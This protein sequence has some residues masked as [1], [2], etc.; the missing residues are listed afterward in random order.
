[1]L[2]LLLLWFYTYFSTWSYYYTTKQ[3][4]GY[5]FFSWLRPQIW[6]SKLLHLFLLLLFVHFFA[7]CCLFVI[8]S[9]NRNMIIIN[10]IRGKNRLVWF[11]TWANTIVHLYFSS[12]VKEIGCYY[13]TNTNIKLIPI[14]THSSKMMNKSKE[15]KVTICDK[16]EL[17]MKGKHLNFNVHLCM[18]LSL[19]NCW[20]LKLEAISLWEKLLK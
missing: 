14:L 11:F 1:M 12:N 5:F 3:G 15:W 19:N 18:K 8:S 9:K 4:F 20:L 16:Y 17:Q 6:P 7:T 2:L 10:M 13:F